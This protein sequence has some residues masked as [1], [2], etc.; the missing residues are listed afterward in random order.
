MTNKTDNT[1]ARKPESLVVELPRV[2]N[3]LD[4][5]HSPVEQNSD[6][7]NRSI[8]NTGLVCLVTE[9]DSHDIYHPDGVY[10]MARFHQGNNNDH[11]T[12]KTYI[13]EFLDG[14]G[15]R[16]RFSMSNLGGILL[17]DEAES[18]PLYPLKQNPGRL[19]KAK[20]NGD[21]SVS[22]S[23]VL[24]SQKGQ[25]VIANNVQD[26]TFPGKYRPGM[27]QDVEGED[28]TMQVM[29]GQGLVSAHYKVNDLE[30]IF[31]LESNAPQ[32]LSHEGR[33]RKYHA[34]QVPQKITS[35]LAYA[36][37]IQGLF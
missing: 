31:V 13:A 19:V 30:G 29:G 7:L 3:A 20:L 33:I 36:L 15:R 27:I 37:S 8:G 25:V 32:E 35:L 24:E 21:F 4:L 2:L 23:D 14:S 18:L 16:V 9:Y 5:V 12:E 11:G 28:Y 22:R 26:R 10:E 17:P 1:S 34:S 6:L